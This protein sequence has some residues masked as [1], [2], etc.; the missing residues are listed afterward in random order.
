MRRFSLATLLLAMGFAAIALSSI[1]DSLA[2]VMTGESMQLIYPMIA[3]AVAG[4]AFCCFRGV[5]QRGGFLRILGGLAAG[6]IF[7][8]RWITKTSRASLVKKYENRQREQRVNLGRDVRGRE[9]DDSEQQQPAA[10]R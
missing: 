2:R 3:G 5:W 8:M 10:R 6:V 7:G 1:R 4:G 9:A